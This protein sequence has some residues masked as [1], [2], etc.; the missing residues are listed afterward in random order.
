V[1]NEPAVRSE[2]GRVSPPGGKKGPEAV[3]RA[4]IDAA[5]EAAGWAVQDRDDANL[6]AARGVAVRAFKLA[7]GFGSGSA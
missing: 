5:L 3:A 4:H 6:T 2:R 1:P 7:D